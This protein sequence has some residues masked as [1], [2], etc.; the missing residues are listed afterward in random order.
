MKNK[1]MIALCCLGISAGAALVFSFSP[2]PAAPDNYSL[3]APSGQF[4]NGTFPLFYTNLDTITNS[5][6]DSMRVNVRR[7]WATNYSSNTLNS[8]T[9]TACVLK[10]AGTPTVTVSLYGSG[11]NAYSYDP[12]PL[13]TYTCAPSSLTVP[14]SKTY[15]VNSGA[16][17]PYTDYVWVATTSA[18]STVSWKAWDLLR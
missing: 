16:G 11:N 15:A 10:V 1:I 9:Y 18:S 17:N 5:S 2:A 8:L 14:V 3:A 12:T 13:V 6:V 7:G 4:S